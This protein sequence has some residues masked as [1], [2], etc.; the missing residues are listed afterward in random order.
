MNEAEAAQFELHA[1]DYEQLVEHLPLPATLV[2]DNLILMVNAAMERLIGQPRARLLGLTFAAFIAAEDLPRVAERHRRRLAGEPVSPEAEFDMQL[3]DGRRVPVRT[4]MTRVELRGRNLNLGVV[5]DIRELRAAQ[6]ALAQEA[7]QVAKQ[8]E[9]LMR[10]TAPAIE[11][12]RGV[13]V[14]PLIGQ[15][16]ADRSERLVE[17][18]VSAISRRRTHQ[19]VLDLTGLSFEAPTVLHAVSRIARSAALLGARACLVG[20][21][22]ALART[23]VELELELDTL[24]VYASLAEALRSRT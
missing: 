13:T 6:S 11:V 23:F 15:F 19:L 4:R 17:D 10:L 5:L 16:D 2:E 18:V 14:M 22:P 20:I 8:R 12:A 21:S 9:A 1:A 3:P 24:E 7:E